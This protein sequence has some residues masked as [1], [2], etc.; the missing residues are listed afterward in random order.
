[1]KHI[2]LNKPKQ[3]NLKTTEIKTYK[4][5]LFYKIIKSKQSQIQKIEN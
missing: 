4:Y 2:N 3:I 1:M 5:N